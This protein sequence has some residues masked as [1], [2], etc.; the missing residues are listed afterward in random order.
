M[1]RSR[2][3]VAGAVLVAIAAAIAWRHLSGR[4]STDDAQIDGH[5]VPVSARVGGTVDAVK[6]ADNQFVD[7]G[8]ALVLIDARD[9]QVALQRARAD[10]AEAEAS[11]QAAR[12]TVPVT[13]T[14]TASQLSSAESDIGT[15]QARLRS[16]Q[17][18]LKDA[19][20]KEKKADQD[21]ARIT[22]LHD[23]DELSQQEFDNVVL[24]AES[25]RT[26]RDAA[27][28]AVKEAEEGVTAAGARL[29]EAKTAPQQ[30]GIM[31]ARAA[32][33]EARV[34]QARA[35]LARAQLD[36]DYASVKAPAAGYVSKKTVEVGQVVQPGQPL[37]AIV[38]LDDIWVTANF[39]ESQLRKIWPGQRAEVAVDAYGGRRYQGHVESISPATG[40]R[41][42][43]LP[44]ENASGNYVKVVQ[45]V[46]VKILI[47]KGQD[48]EHV[49]RPGM[50]VVPTVFVK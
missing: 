42:S 7:A 35:A 45:R 39:K 24:T 46:P 3:I 1:T 36:L 18:R 28:A 50:S 6:V 11:S 20:A 2:W 9:Y 19:Q 8:T 44:P 33:A 26:A 17:A 4:E 43:L 48:S 47:E 40:A 34:V 29:S 15:A 37:L 32:S 21:L 27:Q 41:F 31:R 14:T 22:T 10:L 38:P 30:V 23:K 49:L 13:S 5:I 25:A 16:A 12:T